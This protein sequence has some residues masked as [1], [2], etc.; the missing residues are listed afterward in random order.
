L[1]FRYLTK[2]VYSSA[3]IAKLSGFEPDEIL[4]LLKISTVEEAINPDIYTKLSDD[5]YLKLEAFLKFST[6]A[7]NV[8]G[9]LKKESFSIGTTNILDTTKN[10]SY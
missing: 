2:S 7:C 8:V 6:Q 9:A 10:V 4:E 3:Q 5:N 1:D